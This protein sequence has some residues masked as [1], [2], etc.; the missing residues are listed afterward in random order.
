MLRVGGVVTRVVG[1]LV[2]NVIICLGRN[3]R[4]ENRESGS[5]LVDKKQSRGSGD[6]RRGVRFDT[7]LGS[8]ID[9]GGRSVGKFDSSDI[10]W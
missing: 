1:R 8:D 6:R 2:V 5:G 10:C 9:I 4:A 7:R 3:R